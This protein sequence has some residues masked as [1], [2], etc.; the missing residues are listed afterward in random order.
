MN[1]KAFYDCL[2]SLEF[3]WVPFPQDHRIKIFVLVSYI[4]QVVLNQ[5]LLSDLSN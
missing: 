2:C 3:L 4:Q 5:C 1:L